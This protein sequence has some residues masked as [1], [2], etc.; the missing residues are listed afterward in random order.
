MNNTKDKKRS[1]AGA[2]LGDDFSE[3]KKSLLG[4]PEFRAAYDELEPEFE[5]IA[6]LIA[7]R[8]RRGM[9]QDDLAEAVGT[10][11]PAIARIESGRYRGMSVATLEK[12]ARALD[13]KL[14]IRFE[15]AK[16]KR[17]RARVG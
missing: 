11:Q 4:D 8:G 7:L 1:G 6:S 15:E 16:K 5:L 12:M 9:S 17:G 13:A 2:G 14:V 10:K 3:Y